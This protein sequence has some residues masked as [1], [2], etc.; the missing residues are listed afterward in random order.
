MIHLNAA[1]ARAPFYG[2]TNDRFLAMADGEAEVMERA[3]AG[4]HV[5]SGDPTLAVPGAGTAVLHQCGH[6]AQVVVPVAV[7]KDGTVSFAAPADCRGLRL[8]FD[9]FGP[10]TLPRSLAASGETEWLGDFT[11]YAAGTAGVRV[12]N[13]GGTPVAEGTVN[14]H[15]RTATAGDALPVAPPGSARA[16]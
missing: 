2:V 15:A 10:L 4:L 11:L 3:Y 6:T 14:I 8:A 13:D 9:P 7:K 1:A 12:V 16:R 5:R